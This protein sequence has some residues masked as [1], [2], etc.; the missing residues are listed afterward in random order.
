MVL[1]NQHKDDVIDVNKYKGVVNVSKVQEENSK[2]RYIINQSNDL[3]RHALDYE[4]E[5]QYDEAMFSN[6]VGDETDKLDALFSDATNGRLGFATDVAI[7]AGGM[8]V[9]HLELQEYAIGDDGELLFI[10]G[11]PVVYLV[12]SLIQELIKEGKTIED[13]VEIIDGQLG[14]IN[15]VKHKIVDHIAE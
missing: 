13:I 5:Y 6:C 3:I 15:D 7:N 12:K 1:Y 2:M 14:E 10:G 9:S 11:Y 8:L 4:H